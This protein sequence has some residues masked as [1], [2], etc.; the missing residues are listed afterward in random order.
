MT[1]AFLSDAFSGARVGVVGAGVIGLACARALI[2]C[3][4]RVTL[5]ERGRAGEGAAWAAAGMLAAAAEN[6]EEAGQSTEEL[7]LGLESLRLW[8]D[9][10]AGVSRESGRDIGFRQDGSLLVALDDDEER[11]LRAF[12]KSSGALGVSCI[13]LDALEARA[14]E[15]GLSPD[16]RFAVFAPGDWSVDARALVAAL[17]EAVRAGGGT[18]KEGVEVG[19]VV[20]GPK[21]RVVGRS[22]TGGV[23][24][25]MEVV[26]VAPGWRAAALASRIPALAEILPVKGQMLAVQAGSAAP[27]HVV[28]GRGAYLTPRADGRVVIGATSE[29]GVATETVEP[30]AIERLHAAGL[31][32]LPGLA[33]APVIETWSGVRPGW[34]GH[35]RAPLIAEVAPRIVAA[36]GHYRNGV[37]LAPVTAARVAA[38]AE[39][40]LAPRSRG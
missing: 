20:P 19:D 18:I 27:R 23:D 15:P 16:V 7:T 12:V 4:A 35:G 2:A 29:A 38:L 32:L 34:S 25:E 30:A 10:A 28:R 21:P 1:R 40:A 9:F 24:D 39:Q 26:V 22:A 33:T 3:G 6:L 17:A 5:Y 36:G 31:R 37:L 11:R 13:G 8:P 14:N